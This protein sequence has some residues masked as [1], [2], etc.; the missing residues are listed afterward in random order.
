M[1][2]FVFY[3]RASEKEYTSCA[4]HSYLSARPPVPLPARPPVSLPACLPARQSLCPPAHQSLCLPACLSARPPA[5]QSLC[6]PA[7]PPVSLPAR[8]SLCPPARPSACLPARQ[9]LCLPLWWLKSLVP[10][11]IFMRFSINSASGSNPHSKTASQESRAASSLFILELWSFCSS[12][13]VSVKIINCWSHFIARRFIR[14]LFCCC[15]VSS[16]R[17]YCCI[18]GGVKFFWSIFE[19][20]I[21][22]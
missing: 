9:S 10:S 4:C 12:Q 1:G 15:L 13:Y 5:R 11:K 7:R 14:C 18:A 22:I 17:D 19:Y 8:Q 20:L 16:I 2:T 3:T 6:P 21:F